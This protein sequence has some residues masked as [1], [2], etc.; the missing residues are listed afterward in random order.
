MQKIS[1]IIPTYNRAAYIGRA[2]LSVLRQKDFGGEI[3]IIDDGSED[4][5]REVIE[6][7]PQQHLI[8]YYFNER[9]GVAAARNYGVSLARYP[10]IAFL[11]SD[12][13][14]CQGKLV[15]QMALLQ[16]N[17]GHTICHTGEKWLRRGR[18]L[19]QKKIH[20]P[21]AGD[22]FDHCL[23]ICGVGMSTVLMYKELFVE[24]GGFDTALPC[25]EDYDL[26]LRI[27]SKNRFLLAGE[28][29][30]VKEGGRA[31]Q[32][33]AIYR[34]GMDKHRIYAIEKLLGSTILNACQR[35]QA[36]A[37]LEKKCAIYGNGCIKHGHTAKGEY[38]LAL[39]EK[40]KQLL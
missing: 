28:A 7:L 13:H 39:P 17:P 34:R 31:D 10:L 18:H 37:E 15:R 23:Q 3:I 33:S 1:V 2:A 14:W 35:Q 4:N 38:Y 20:Q 8:R 26:W 16:Q 30:I 19:N 6:E 21:R 22:I 11:D 24:S 36:V 5:T 27:S 12:D 32:L 9:A 25:C 29:L 40:Y